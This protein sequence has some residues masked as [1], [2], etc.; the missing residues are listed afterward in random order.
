MKN[1]AYGFST[2]LIQAAL[3]NRPPATDLSRE[4]IEILV[5]ETNY[6]IADTDTGNYTVYENKDRN[7]GMDGPFYISWYPKIHEGLMFFEPVVHSR[8][9]RGRSTDVTDEMRRRLSRFL[10]LLGFQ[11]EIAITLAEPVVETPIHFQ[12]S[13]STVTFMFL[14]EF[15]EKYISLYLILKEIYEA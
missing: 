10:S 4:Q 3:R 5:A 13:L 2:K 6:H 12:T 7:N 9:I 8:F 14:S 15:K 11:S 1:F